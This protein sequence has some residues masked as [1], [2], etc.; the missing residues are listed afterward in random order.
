MSID[1]KTEALKQRLVSCQV[2][3]ITIWSNIHHSDYVTKR[4]TL[5]RVRDSRSTTDTNTAKWSE[6][7]GTE[8]TDLLPFPETFT[9][10]LSIAEFC[11]AQGRVRQGSARD[12]P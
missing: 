8:D 10:K 2:A 7:I 3:S 11:E 4:G 12:G 6:E 9:N 5:R 1:I